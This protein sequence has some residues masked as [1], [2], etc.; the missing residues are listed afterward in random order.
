ME[1]LKLVPLA[2][3]TPTGS[4]LLCLALISV[5][6]LKSTLALSPLLTNHFVAPWDPD[7][8]FMSL[9][10]RFPQDLITQQNELFAN[11]GFPEPLITFQNP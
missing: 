6:S 3:P 1:E 11:T 9:L 10:V 8:Q 5:S 4:P 7:L 2:D